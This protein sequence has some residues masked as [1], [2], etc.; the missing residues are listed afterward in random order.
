MDP[1]G[2]E[3]A[4]LGIVATAVTALVWIVKFLMNEIK[5]SLDKNSVSHDKVARATRLN[6]AVSQETLEFMKNLNGRLAKITEQRIHEQTV[7]HQTIKRNE[8]E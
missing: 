5:T 3:M 7:E 4:A 8:H 2:V 6:T 1:I